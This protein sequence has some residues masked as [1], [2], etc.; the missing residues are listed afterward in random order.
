M[1]TH[2]SIRCGY[3]IHAVHLGVLKTKIILTHHSRGCDHS[4]YTVH[5]GV[6]KT[7]V[8]LTHHSRGCDHSIQSGHLDWWCS[9]R[10]FWPCRD[11]D[12]SFQPERRFSRG[13]EVFYYIAS[14]NGEFA[15]SNVDMCYG[16]Q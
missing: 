6:L 4:I 9:T 14:G 1:L 10:E 13:S 3:I 16:E 5:L 8:M 2:D 15:Y 7:K 12:K 11:C